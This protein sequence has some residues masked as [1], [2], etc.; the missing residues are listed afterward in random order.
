MRSVLEAKLPSDLWSFE[1]KIIASLNA[2]ADA[3]LVEVATVIKGQ[4]FDWGKS[5][6]IL[7]ALVNDLATEPARS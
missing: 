4:L 1:G 2:L 5:N 7:E 6:R 3:T